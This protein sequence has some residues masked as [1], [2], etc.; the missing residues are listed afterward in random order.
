[1]IRYLFPYWVWLI[2]SIIL[3][4]VYSTANVYFLPLT[5]DIVKGIS[6]K[7]SVFFTNQILN[8][9]GLIL[10]RVMADKAQLYLTTKMTGQM[11]IDIQMKIYDRL[12]RFS[13]ALYSKWKLGEL[14]TRLFSDTEKL[15]EG[16][17]SLFRD[18]IPQTITF[19]GVFVYLLSSNWKL[20]LITIMGIP[21]FLALLPKL[22]S[23]LKQATRHA[24]RKSGSITHVSQ[25]TLANIKLVQAYTMEGFESARMTKNLNMSLL[26]SLKGIWLRIKSEFLIE[27]LQYSLMV[28]VIWYGGRQVTQG[29]LSGDALAA[30]FMGLLLL[31]DPV[32]KLSKT[33]TKLT[34]SLVSAERVFKL[35]DT[36]DLIVMPQSPKR[37]APISGNI[38]FDQVSFSYDEYQGD[39]LTNISLEANE[40]EVIA[41]V[42]LSGAGKTTLMSLIP[43]FYDPTSGK[44]TLDG[45][46]LREFDL[47]YLR[48]QMAIVP[49][50]DILF[51][52]SILDNILYGSP[53]ASVEQVIEAARMA[54]A[55]EFIQ[56][57]PGNLKALIGDRGGRLS[58]GQRQRLSIARAILRNPKI[59]LLDE[60]TSAL[61]SY[62]EKLVQAALKNLMKNRTT[63]VIAHRLSTVQHATKIIVLENGKIQE[64][65]TH[66]QLLSQKGIY[67]KLY[68]L[69]FQKPTSTGS[70]AGAS[71]GLLV[72]DFK[73]LL[74]DSR[75]G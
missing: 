68:M 12:L 55:W 4:L 36:Q 49:Q 31:I 11:M 13:Q 60:A 63:F 56:K 9:F 14:L 42:G 3:S 62:S 17:L 33:Y 34:L 58:G 75:L 64:V 57:M 50:E 19:I 65:G 48:S 52:G 18:L 72:D 66:D 47:E 7:N 6:D 20:T 23:K 37:P 41:F 28:F 51:R 24:M 71:T 2:V 73:G 22:T 54:N 30:F 35:E 43:R 74:D 69:Q 70:V 32:I 39:V 53:N 25:E 59:L 15:K 67:E 16:I 26:I 27:F 40:G 21:V 10:L 46:D 29:D 5:E 8:L 44:V 1:M 45:I 38:V 61:D